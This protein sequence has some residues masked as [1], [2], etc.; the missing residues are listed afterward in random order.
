MQQGN[1][2]GEN[3]N[4]DDMYQ[5]LLTLLTKCPQAMTAVDS[6]G[7]T[8]L[9]H[10]MT[11]TR[12]IMDSKCYEMLL[13][14]CPDRVAHLAIRSVIQ[15]SWR[16]DDVRDMVYAKMDALSVEDVESGLLP[17]MMV[18]EG[19]DD[20]E[21]LIQLSMVYELLCLNPGVLKYYY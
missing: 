6:S 13:D 8:P 5:S 9:H 21:D 18:A 12:Q 20:V 7:R 14:H 17:F 3:D 19:C 2:D 4:D 10:A 16:W 1:D 15:S 11:S